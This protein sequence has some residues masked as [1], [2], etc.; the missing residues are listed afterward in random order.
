[1]VAHTTPAGVVTGR[2][3]S[4]PCL[5]LFQGGEWTRPPVRHTM[6]KKT[7]QN[8]FCQNFAKFPQT[9]IIFGKKVA[10]GLK[11]CEH[12]LHVDHDFISAK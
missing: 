8:Y 12:R 11:L 10:N 4:G 5:P 7:A 3:G 2:G 6:S 1:M 9:L